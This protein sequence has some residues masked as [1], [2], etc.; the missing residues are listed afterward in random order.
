MDRK[1]TSGF[2]SGGGIFCESI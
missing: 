1:D 2:V